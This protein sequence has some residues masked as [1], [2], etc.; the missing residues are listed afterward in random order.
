MIL[1]NLKNS[2]NPLGGALQVKN[3]KLKVKSFSKIFSTFLTFF[4][5]LQLIAGIFLFVPKP[6]EAR[7]AT[8]RYLDAT[9]CVA[10]CS[11]GSNSY[12]LTTRTCGS[13]SD[14]VY[15]TLANVVSAAVAGD[16]IQ[17]RQDT[18]TLS[19]IVTVSKANLDIGAYPGE[20]PTINTTASYYV[21]LEAAGIKFHG[22]NYTGLILQTKANSDIYN[23]FFYKLASGV[24]VRKGTGHKIY[25]NKFAGTG[26]LSYNACIVLNPAGGDTGGDIYNNLITP[27]FSDSATTSYNW[28]GIFIWDGGAYKQNWNIYNNYITGWAYDAIRSGDLNSSST[29][30]IK[31]NIMGMGGIQSDSSYYTVN[32]TNSAPS[33]TLTNNYLAPP[34]TYSAVS[35]SNLPY[36]RNVDIETNNLYAVDK[37]SPNTA[38][39]A[40]SA[41]IQTLGP[42][43]G[44]FTFSIDD[45]VD[46]TMSQVEAL[47][48]TWHDNGFHGTAFVEGGRTTLNFYQRL[49]AL[50]ADGHEVQSHTYSH[51]TASITNAFTATYSG[52]DTPQKVT[53]N[54]T[55]IIFQTSGSDTYTFTYD[56][57]NI[58]KNLV[59][60]ANLAA[61]H[62][63]ITTEYVNSL[64]TSYLHLTS[65]F[66]GDFIYSGGKSTITLDRTGIGQ[67]FF[68]N[69]LVDWATELETQTG[70]IAGSVSTLALPNTIEDA[71]MTAALKAANYIG[72][73]GSSGGVAKL[74][75]G[76]INVY[77]L[78]TFGGFLNGG[79]DITAGEMEVK[80]RT[81]MVCDWMLQNA[82]LVNFY[83]HNTTQ[84]SLEQLNWIA[85]TINN[86]SGV[87]VLPEKTAIWMLGLGLKAA[88]QTLNKGAKSTVIFLLI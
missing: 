76:A 63:S 53:V 78:T 9:A 10:S 62:W 49:S 55:Q 82:L 38:S 17:T 43:Y 30:V 29:Y 27:Y 59:D 64:A 85:Q 44:L 75:L 8:I 45:A 57:T 2:L 81:A 36:T 80:A 7:A 31:N 70:Q 66:L 3:S 69:E 50:L 47:L 35:A 25:N 13:G 20:T 5:I 39:S 19:A 74:G 22:F 32:I 42:N 79:N 48:N 68:K 56:N 87:T 34:V 46:I 12:D 72:V 18:Y 88:C 65:L 21:S 52:T 1:A 33:F 28:H 14:V 6:Q 86:C 77:G 26:T 11:N 16:T 71:G 84:V 54:A 4:L 40:G 83:T 58:V 51:T 15:S 41:G 24:N 23:N 37:S 67:G 61:K 73:R 60:D